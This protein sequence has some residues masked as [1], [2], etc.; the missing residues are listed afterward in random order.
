M[1]SAA[2][3]LSSCATTLSMPTHGPTTG[4]GLQNR[5][6]AKTYSEEPW[7]DLLSARRCSSSSTIREPRKEVGAVQLA[8]L[9]HLSGAREICPA[10]RLSF[11]I[12]CEAAGATQR[13]RALVFRVALSRQTE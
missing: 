11:A 12:R 9:L 5:N 4:Q 1:I 8:G 7:E 3:F 13:T 10:S 6:C 2:I